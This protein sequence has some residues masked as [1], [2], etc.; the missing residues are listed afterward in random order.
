LYV[1]NIVQCIGKFNGIGMYVYVCGLL[2][3]Y[4]SSIWDKFVEALFESLVNCGLYCE[5]LVVLMSHTKFI[6]NLLSNFEC[7]T[8]GQ[9]QLPIIQ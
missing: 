7:E 4:R 6:L 9:T 5:K 8:Y 1:A 3:L 2:D